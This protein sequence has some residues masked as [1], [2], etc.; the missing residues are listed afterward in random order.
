MVYAGLLLC[1]IIDNRDN[2]S[3]ALVAS[4]GIWEPR[5]FVASDA[6]F[7]KES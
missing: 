4:G 3:V 7:I 1:D 2:M 5:R 6:I